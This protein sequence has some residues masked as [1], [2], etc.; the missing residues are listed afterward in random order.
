V[1]TA[2]KSEYSY[3]EFCD[4]ARRFN[5]VELLAAI[6]R[7]AIALPDDWAQKPKFRRTPPWSLAALAKASI[8]H[9]NRHRSTPVRPG[10]VPDGCAIYS[11]PTMEELKI[12]GSDPVFNF[13]VRTA[14]EQFPCQEAVYHELARAEAFFNGYSGRKELEVVNEAALIELFGA[15]VR[16]AVGAAFVLWVSTTFNGGFFDPAWLGQDD[17]A[18]ILQEVPRE[19]VESVVATSF[20]TDID[21]F[22]QMAVGAPILPGLERYTFNPLT[23]RPLLRLDDGR[24]LAPVPQLIMHRLSPIEQYYEGVG[25][26]RWGEAFTRDLGELLE[27]YIGRQLKTLPGVAVHAEI[28][29]GGKRKNEKRSVDWIVVFDDLVLLVDAKATRLAAAPR[30]GAEETKSR[31]SKALSYGFE[32]IDRTHQ[33]IL[34]GADGFSQLPTDRPFVGLVATLDPWYVTNSGFA[35]DFL[36]QPRIPALV[37]SV[38]SIEMLVAFG[39]RRPAS[40]PLKVISGDFEMSTWDFGTSLARFVK[41]TDANPILDAAWETFPF[42]PALRQLYPPHETPDP[43][44]GS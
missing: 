38:R 18:E 42:N 29:Y 17:F 26:L 7:T 16:E 1:T 30:A 14:Y 19:H 23:A 9:G 36:H 32:Q 2:V 8:M 4:Y 13:L 12:A 10:N 25:R 33:L 35:R 11:N 31:V 41:P 34:D 20:A 21:G 27:D 39:Q 24:F 22:K 44:S 5:Q 6:A 40:E 15:P 43:Q 37:G 28:L 3:R